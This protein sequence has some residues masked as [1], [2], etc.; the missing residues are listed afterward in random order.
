MHDIKCLQTWNNH[1]LSL[2]EIVSSGICIYHHVEQKP[3]FSSHIWSV[4]HSRLI[5]PIV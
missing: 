1:V 2:L 3:K 5:M 4:S